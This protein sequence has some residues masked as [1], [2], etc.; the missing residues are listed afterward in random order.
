[1]VEQVMLLLFN[2]FSSSTI[3]HLHLWVVGRY[4]K[5]IIVQCTNVQSLRNSFSPNPTHAKKAALSDFPDV[6]VF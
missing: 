1:M 4:E 2:Y 6:C 3:P 5:R